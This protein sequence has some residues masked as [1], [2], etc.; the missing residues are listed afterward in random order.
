[1]EMND[2]LTEQMQAYIALNNLFSAEDSILVAVSGGVDSVVLAHGLK[3]LGVSFALAHVNFKLRGEESDGD[4]VLV[5]QLADL[6]EKPLFEMEVD[7]KVYAHEHN[8]NTQLAA[9]EI[10]YAYFER[11]CQDQGFTKVAVAHH[12]DDQAETFFIN[13]N[14]RAGLKGLSGIPLVNDKIVRP[15][16]FASRNQ[17]EA[18]A[19]DHNLAFRTDSSNLSDN[20]LRNK[21]RHHLLPVAEE[22][23]P[24]FVS[25]LNKSM[26]HLRDTEEMLD[27]VVRLKQAEIFEPFGERISVNIEG[28]VTLKPLKTWLFY[29]LYDFGFNRE[30]LQSA[31]EAITN[32][33]VGKVFFSPSH[34]LLIDR[35]KVFISKVEPKKY[36]KAVSVEAGATVISHPLNLTFQK[37]PLSPD[38]SWKTNSDTALFDFDGLEFPLTIRPWQQ[39]DRFQ[40]FGMKGSKLVS[41]LLIDQKV[42][43]WDKNR[44]FVLA[45][46]KTILWVIGYRV[47]GHAK[48]TAQTKRIYRI[49]LA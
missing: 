37:I 41:D 31:A 7:A 24:G 40:P 35:R 16:L 32:S 12:A 48:L 45:Q 34:S 22:V 23:M 38:L 36:T 30:Q 13:M 21:I 10:R 46:G 26:L 39:G 49:S 1:M 44:V 3:Q 25:G 29:L 28:L 20:Y 4:A 14:R 18:Y 9:R 5:R 11:L 33:Q 42:S 6:W 47:S 17:I 8:L 43:Q 2:P 15:L 27:Q 19:A